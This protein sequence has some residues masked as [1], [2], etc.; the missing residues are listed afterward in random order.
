MSRT[1]GEVV[2]AECGQVRAALAERLGDPRREGNLVK[3]CCLLRESRHP[4]SGRQLIGA[5]RQPAGQHLLDA[6]Q[7]ADHR[8][9]RPVR[10]QRLCPPLRGRHDGTQVLDRRIGLAEGAADTIQAGHGVSFWMV[11]QSLASR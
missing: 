3:A 6:G 5:A 4:V 8:A 9:Y 1:A 11:T 2:L 10:A 7:V